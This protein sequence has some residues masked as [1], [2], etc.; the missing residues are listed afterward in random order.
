MHS[1]LTRILQIRVKPRSRKSELEQLDGGGWVAKIKAP[2]LTARPIR[3][4]SP[5]SP[6]ISQPAKVT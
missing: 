6:A 5:L 1:P 3:N 2:P 4:Y